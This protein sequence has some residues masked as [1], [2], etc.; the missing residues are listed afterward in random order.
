MKNKYG[1]CVCG[2]CFVLAATLLAAGCSG[3]SPTGPVVTPGQW[4]ARVTGDVTVEKSG[5][6]VF[7]SQGFDPATGAPGLLVT[8]ASSRPRTGLGLFLV[9]PGN[10]QPGQATYQVGQY[11]TS[12]ENLFEQELD[13]GRVY[14]QVLLPDEENDTEVFFSVSGTVQ[15]SRV[16]ANALEG[17]FELAARTTDFDDEGE[18][19]VQVSGDF[20]AIGF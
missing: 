3:D 1:I 12:A 18:R 6:A 8:L 17:K 14:I 15:I 4:T 7:T 9:F 5:Q 20:S 10:F 2:I 16:A 19:T 13:P 11:D